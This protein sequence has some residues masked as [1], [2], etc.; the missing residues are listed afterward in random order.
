MEPKAPEKLAEGH[1]LKTLIFRTAIGNGTH[2]SA[3]VGDR[4]ILE[5]T[6]ARL[7]FDGDWSAIDK[8]QTPLGFGI[9]EQKFKDGKSYVLRHFVPFINVDSVMYS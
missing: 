3:T 5:I 1:K 7:E 4:G 8:G 9:R 6:P 2:S